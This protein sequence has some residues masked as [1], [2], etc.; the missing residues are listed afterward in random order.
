[1]TAR[2]PLT[3]ITGFLGSGKTTLV[4]KFLHRKGYQNTAVIDQTASKV[5]HF[6]GYE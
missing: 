1:M 5:K 4:R 3:V 2:I 6:N